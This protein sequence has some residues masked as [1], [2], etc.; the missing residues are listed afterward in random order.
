MEKIKHYT[1]TEIG[2]V[3]H[4]HAPF[5]WYKPHRY[6][7]AAIR[8]ITKSWSGHTA[9][10]V[11]F[12]GRK[13]IL[14]NDNKKTHIMPFEQ[15][16]SDSI[17]SIKRTQLTIFEK[18]K[19][20]ILASQ[21]ISVTKYDY[22]AIANHLI[23]SLTGTWIGRTGKNAESKKVCSELIAYIYEKLRG[24]YPE[25][26]KSTPAELYEDARFEEIYYG[27]AKNLF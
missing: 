2:D 6:I 1:Q 20:E 3:V 21:E 8:K 14:E 17:I 25:N 16:A 12:A 9:L 24:Y 26:Y 23:Y 5:I 22:E 10:I 11:T 4:R 13:M 15:W 19:I 18:K 7:S 27:P